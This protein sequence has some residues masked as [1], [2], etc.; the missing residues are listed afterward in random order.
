MSI[1]EAFGATGAVF[2]FLAFILALSADL[3]SIRTRH[4]PIPALAWSAFSVA[5]LAFLA[6][7]WTGVAL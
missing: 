6:G 1:P 2:L 4:T 5:L 7:I 3:D